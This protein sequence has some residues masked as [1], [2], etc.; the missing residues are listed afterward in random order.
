MTVETTT[1]RNALV[2]RDFTYN[3]R[4]YDAF[5]PGVTKYL[6]EFNGANWQVDDT[7]HDP[8]PNWTLNITEAGAGDTTTNLTDLSGGGLLITTGTADGDGL[9]MQLGHGSTGAGE[10]IDLSG[11]NA[12]YLGIELAF[13]DADQIEFLFGACITD[14]DCFGAVTDGMYFRSIDETA[15]LNF[16]TELNSVESA[17]AVATLADAT[18]IK[19][20]MLYDV[21]G[22]VYVYVNDS[23]I[24]TVHDS[25]ATFPNDEL[26]R[27]TFEFLTG[28]GNANTCT[29][30]W[31]RMI[32]IRS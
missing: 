14:A 10:N 22:Y 27:T 30:R 24:T 6:Q 1:K 11:R 28:E 19:L 26:L 16:V 31:M 15:V 8:S 2:Y 17:V 21:D 23:L 4:W 7:T 29:V 18:Y 12:L 9:Q 13:S 20:E 25:A 3:H 5:G 32:H